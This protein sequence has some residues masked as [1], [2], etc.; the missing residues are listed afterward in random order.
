[1]SLTPAVVHF[2]CKG[3]HR[4]SS[5]K[6]KRTNYLFAKISRPEIARHFLSPAPTAMLDRLV[7]SGRLTTEEALLASEIP[8]AED[9]T[10]ESDSGGHTDNRPLG[11]LFSTIYELRG[12]LAGS[13][14][15]TILPRLGAAGGLGTPHAIA[16]AFA[17]GAAY[18][19]AGSVHQAC[20]ES[21]VSPPVKDM[22]A[23]AGIADVAMTSSADMFELGGRVQVLKRGTMMPQRGNHL[24]GLY[25]KYR[26]IEDIP[27]PE[28][29]VLERDIFKKPVQDVWK[30]TEEFFRGADPSS[31]EKA[32]KDGRHKMSLIF[33]WYLGKSSQWA[34][35]GVEDRR[36]DYQIW[37]GPSIGA[38]NAWTKRSFLE[39]VENRKVQAVS[40]N[41]MK[42]AAI[43][44]RTH[45]I[46]T[47]GVPVSEKDMG[48]KPEPLL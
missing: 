42:G 26:S 16:S 34:V 39:K 17:L 21:G 43:I 3:L 37:C 22:L 20:V 24:Y 27:E 15:Y 4:D 40:G 47:Y 48:Y 44:T 32:Q 1:M 14:G 2:A 25:Q 30:E 41:L 28:I 23:Q 31:M 11:P 29:A 18:V 9:I 5:G 13:Y 12:E 38:F 33:R 7:G 35:E 6:I 45:Q 36:L 8:L 10:V 46:R 19:L